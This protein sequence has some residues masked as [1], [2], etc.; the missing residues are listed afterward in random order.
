MLCVIVM[1]TSMLMHVQI[2]QKKNSNNNNNNKHKTKTTKNHTPWV[3]EPVIESVILHAAL[4]FLKHDFHDLFQV[5]LSEKTSKTCGQQNKARNV[6]LE[7]HLN[8]QVWANFQHQT[9]WATPWFTPKRIVWLSRLVLI[10]IW[11]VVSTHLNNISQ[12]GNLP[13]VG[14]KITNIWNQHL[15]IHMI[16]LAGGRFHW[17]HNMIFQWRKTTQHPFFENSEGKVTYSLAMPSTTFLHAFTWSFFHHF[18]IFRVGNMM[19][20]S[21]CFLW[22]KWSGLLVELICFWVHSQI[23]SKHK[24]WSLGYTFLKYLGCTFLRIW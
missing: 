15:E 3:V 18:G 5:N 10:T 2:C 11:L 20:S 21:W 17:N 16:Q 6:E 12:I 22:G 1:H 23:K 24:H 13:Q 14:V 9:G 7:I 8:L 19:T 4:D